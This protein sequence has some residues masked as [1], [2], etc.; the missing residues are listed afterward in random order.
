MNILQLHLQ[1]LKAFADERFRFNPHF[2]VIIGENGE[3]KTALLNGVQ[4]ALGA[5][6]QCLGKGYYRG[7]VN[8][9]IRY[10]WNPT[11]KDYE[12]ILPAVVSAQGA[13]SGTE[14]N[15]ARRR[16]TLS[17]K[18]THNK[19]EAGELMDAVAQLLARSKGEQP[20][21]LPVLAHF[22][23]R[24]GGSH[25]KITKK[26]G[27]R[28]RL[29]KAYY[30]CL[31]DSAENKEY[32]RWLYDYDSLI[33]Q[34]KEFEGT[35]EA[36]FAAIAT[37]IP[38]LSDIA[39]HRYEKQLEAVV[40]RRDGQQDH[41]LLSM[42]SDGFRTMVELVAELA[43]RCV[44]LNGR[45]GTEAVI[46]TPGVVMIDELDMHLHPSWQ[47]HVVADLKKAFPMIQ[48]IATTHSPFIVQSLASDELINLNHPSDVAP[49]ELPLDR[50]VTGLMG[51]E[52]VF[53]QENAQ[54]YDLSKDILKGIE[55]Q[56]PGVQTKV[57]QVSDPALRA[58][59]ELK[60]LT[61]K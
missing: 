18:T 28:S 42:M 14:I 4:I 39:Y 15:W 58:L 41:L 46:R 33:K 60:L 55:A 10:V 43:Y 51:V 30:G 50:V 22:G 12:E 16:L 38:Y 56:D 53:G 47:R 1:N 29:E 49:K 23:V 35:R 8:D 57:E 13:L 19:Q 44:L 31:S 9:D 27:R 7:I 45:W 26:H 24:R 11:G 59:L 36:V 2:T 40:S 17:G 21:P 52:S 37:A 25:I 3:G 48:F 32:A 61:K 20:L 34:Q 5:Y 54:L 6:L